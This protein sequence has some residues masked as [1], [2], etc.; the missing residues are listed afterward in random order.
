MEQASL[1]K[2]PGFSEGQPE[3]YSEFLQR[4][5]QLD[6][7]DYLYQLVWSRYHGAIRVLLDNRYVF[8]PYWDHQNGR[9]AA[10]IGQRVEKRPGA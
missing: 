8:Q 9:P 7:H 5:S 2:R 4:L 10:R 1:A 3:Y 6:R